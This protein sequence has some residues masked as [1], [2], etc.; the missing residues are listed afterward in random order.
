MNDDINNST[1]KKRRPGQRMTSTQRKAAQA[2]FLATFEQSANVTQ[3]C[4]AAGIDRSMAYQWL[5][6]DEQFSI[7]YHQAEQ[8]ANDAIRAEI[9]RRGHD[10]VEEPVLNQGQLVYEYEPVLDENG[11]QRKD[12]KG[13]P[14]WKR[15]RMFTVRK[16]SD[17][18]LIFLAK[19]RMPEFRDKSSVDVNTNARS[20]EIYRVRIPDNGRDA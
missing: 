6:H 12:E 17:T 3:A 4:R 20:V 16:Y 19:A 9:F 7:L 15:G 2:A 5:E 14:M 18:L 10:G 13:K 1:P 8:I 11:E